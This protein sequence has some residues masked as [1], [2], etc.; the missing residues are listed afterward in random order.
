MKGD[1][2]AIKLALALKTRGSF[3]RILALR[4]S[5][6]GTITR[7]LANALIPFPFITDIYIFHSTLAIF[8][9]LDSGKCRLEDSHR[10]IRTLPSI[11]YRDSARFLISRIYLSTDGLTSNR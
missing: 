8:L 6:V 3:N 4:F 9:P 10:E 7:K 11:V 2:P 5:G 1:V